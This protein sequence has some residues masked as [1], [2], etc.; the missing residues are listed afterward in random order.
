MFLRE[1]RFKLM[2]NGVKPPASIFRS[3]SYANIDMKLVANW[4]IRLTP[5]QHERFNQLRDRFSTEMEE[6]EAIQD[7]E[8]SQLRQDEETYLAMREQE[9]WRRGQIY[10]QDV[11][12]RQ[13]KREEK[14]EL[15]PPGVELDIVIAREKLEEI[16]NGKR[17]RLKPGKFGRDQQWMDAEFVHTSKSI[18]RCAAQ[19]LVKS[20]KE[21]RA[22]N[23]DC[24]LFQ[25]GTDPDDIHQGL[26]HDGW[27]LSAI[28]ILSASGDEHYS[29]AEVDPLIAN[30]FIQ[31]QSSAVGAYSKIFFKKV[32]FIVC[33]SY[34]IKFVIIVKK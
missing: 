19:P 22:I 13:L 29:E 24:N 10:L 1:N 30:I 27:L 4:L 26:L 14:G 16:A 17:G 32:N 9:D 25:G 8:D 20:W 6:R 31:N 7:M 5:E 3:N 11:Q 34:I 12:Q 2:A 21:A 15:V 23:V 33:S 28:Q 18:G